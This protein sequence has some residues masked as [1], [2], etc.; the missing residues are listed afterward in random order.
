M[1]LLE[2]LERCGEDLTPVERRLTDAILASPSEA[3]FL[4]VQELAG[5]AGADAAAAVRL[6]KKLGFSG[7][8]ELKASLQSQIVT[9]GSAHSR[10]SRRVSPMGQS[11]VLASMI[12]S[13]I[14][15]LNL[16]RDQVSETR[17]AEAA[18]AL[19]GAGR[20]VIYGQGHAMALVDLMARRLNRHGYLAIAVRDGEW[21]APEAA[22]Q[23]RTDD[24]FVGFA[25]YRLPEIIERLVAHARQT[26]AKSLLITDLV[27]IAMPIPPDHL[28][29][30]VRGQPGQSHTLS[31]PML[32]VNA[33][34]LLMAMR[35]DGH[36]LQALQQL[37][38][39]TQKLSGRNAGSAARWNNT[40]PR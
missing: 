11:G 26:G 31:A 18:D 12:D 5:R 37:D 38:A 27:G 8:R 16:L 19:R 7:Y 14:A 24:M 20:I 32:I 2:A 3:A 35:D 25:M 22:A 13:E 28:I 4:S 36:S 9:G 15:S 30:A 40:K 39:V 34:L 29:A 17:L 21:S 10:L 6:A 33:L 1:S 23:L